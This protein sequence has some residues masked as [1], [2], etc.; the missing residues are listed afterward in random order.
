MPRYPGFIGPWDKSQSICAD[1]EITVNWYTE[2]LPQRGKNQFALYPC[3]GFSSWMTFTELGLRGAIDTGARQFVV[4]AGQLYEI[5]QNQTKTARGSAMAQDSNPATM[6]YNSA[7]GELFITTG[8]NG[9]IFTLAT[10][11]LT[12]ELTGTATQGGLLDTFF[13]AFDI[14]TGRIYCS[15][16]N[17]GTTWDPTQYIQ[18][19]TSDAW[20]SMLVVAQPAGIWA[21][22]RKLGDVLY[23]AGTFPFPFAPIPG[24]SFDYG[25]ASTF[26]ISS[27]GGRVSWLTQTEQ[28]AGSVVSARGYTPQRISTP[29][30]ETAI[31]GFLR[32][33]GSIS[34]CE[35]LTYEDQ[36][37]QFTAF[38]F[39][40]SNATFVYDVTTNQWHARTTRNVSKGVNEYWHPRVHLFAYG[41]HLV[42]DRSTGTMSVMDVTY[43]SEANGDPIIRERV[44]PG[45]FNEKQIINTR[46][47][48][49]YLEAG[50]GLSSGQGSNPLVMLDISNDGGKTYGNQR[51]RT[52]GA[53][54]KYQ[55]RVQF[56]K[57]GASRDRV[58]KMTVSDPIPWRIIDGFYNNDG[59]AQAA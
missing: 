4:M 16:P 21:I 29:P 49:I 19:S 6:C 58:Y 57:L 26:S 22:G 33:D 46:V 38:T 34:D 53:L 47:L 32:D 28:G 56:W 10:N 20:V 30:I 1:P 24:A 59:A 37:H 35:A 36:G 54:G 43:G 3:P 9:Y 23:D 27:S 13:V 40:R 51:T 55:T 2:K 39:P 5:F 12:L 48:E 11:T 25:I 52:A 8:G 14:N 45:L 17:D 50:L 15:D 7:S 31:A 18:S 41:K 42:G 44:F